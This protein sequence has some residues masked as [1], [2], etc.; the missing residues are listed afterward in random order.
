MLFSGFQK[1]NHERAVGTF[2]TEATY[3]Y[4]SACNVTSSDPPTGKQS[5]AVIQKKGKATRISGNK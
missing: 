1:L 3:S 5:N 4:T 2:K